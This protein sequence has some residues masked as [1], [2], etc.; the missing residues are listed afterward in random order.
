MDAAVE[1]ITNGGGGMPPFGGQLSEEEINAIA[2][3]VVSATQ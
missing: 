1:Q 3:Y 2:A